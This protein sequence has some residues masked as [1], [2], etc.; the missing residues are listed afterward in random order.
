MNEITYR[1]YGDNIV[2]CERML[3]I[4]QQGF[5]EQNLIKEIISLYPRLW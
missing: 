3:N 2:E 4:I 5:N 1:I